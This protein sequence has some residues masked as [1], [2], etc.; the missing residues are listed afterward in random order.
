MRMKR[1]FFIAFLCV[2]AGRD[3]RAQQA[4]VAE[5][6]DVSV[7]GSRCKF[8]PTLPPLKGIPG[9]PAPFYSYY[10]EF[11][12]GTFSREERPE[13]S[14]AQPGEYNA[15]LYATNN[16]D[17]GDPP[18][19]KTKKKKKPKTAVA[20]AGEKN[21]VLTAFSEGKQAIC[22]QNI[23]QARAK[24]E[25]PIVLSYANRSRA[26]TGGTL[27]FFFNEKAFK[28]RHFD[29]EEARTHHGEQVHAA[30]T[31]VE[32]P[33]GLDWSALALGQQGVGASTPY[34]VPMPVPGA[35]KMLSEARRKYREERAWR[36]ERLRPSEV[37]NLFL[38][39]VGTPSMLKD[40][41]AF[42]HL[43]AIFVPQVAGVEAERYEVELEIVSSHDPNNITV[44]KN[45]AG[46]RRFGKKTLD[47]KVRFQNNGE[48]P[49]STVQVSVDV[50]RGLKASS[51]APQSWYPVCPICP[52]DLAQ[53]KPCLDTAIRGDQLIFTFRNIYLPGSRQAGVAEYDST[54]GFVRYGIRPDRKMQKRP[55]GS[56]AAIVFD[57]NPP[58]QTN[59]A[60]T[61][62][63][64]GISPGLKLAYSF[65]PDAVDAGY[66][67][68]GI[69]L[70]PYKSW[71]IYPQF[72][73]MAG[74]QFE[75]VGAT[76]SSVTKTGN[77]TVFP[78]NYKVDSVVTRRVTQRVP[79]E[80]AFLFRKNLSGW[81]GLGLGGGVRGFQ[82]D[83]KVSS[84][85]YLTGFLQV[86]PGA[87][88][89]KT[90][91]EKTVLPEVNSSDFTWT[92]FLL[93]D[94][95]LGAVRAGPNVGIRLQYFLKGEP[96]VGLQAALEFKF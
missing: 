43:E 87:Q 15:I 26:E 82:E 89:E 67:L 18:P 25:L 50:P 4:E 19:S 24:E 62:F 34:F 27:H 76:E 3:M 46:F 23:R 37:R 57:K 78:I 30:Y 63:R 77:T 21:V 7:S 59:T 51:V 32:A 22:L 55:F 1:L 88:I 81:I 93:A 35:E 48:G 84:E 28:T 14:Y 56:H 65:D 38:T 92:P 94:L 69:S 64:T 85:R 6:F 71:R 36:F 9:A 60:K 73:L 2:G 20:A 52:K 74:R 49:A 66:Y 40:T 54:K 80:G 91:T 70:S 96:K 41:S 68:A 16:Y 5:T 33:L 44:S 83:S 79:V 10:W 42:I 47:Y 11:G 13:H 75:V 53:R 61:R 8:T 12:D 86:Q 95:T 31:A 58:V 29:F 45:R 90:S 17:D 72:E 39:V